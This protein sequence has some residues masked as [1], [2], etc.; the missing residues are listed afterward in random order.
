MTSRERI[1]A[2]IEHRQPDRVPLDMGSTIMSGIM[3]LALTDL[4]K[5]LGLPARVVKVYEPYQMLGEVEADVMEALGIDVMPVEP[6]TLFFG[7]P[8]RDWKPYT[9]WDGTPLLVPGQFHPVPDGAG[10]FVLHDGGDPA[11]P[12]V[13]HTPKQGYYFDKAGDQILHDDFQPPPLAE[14]ERLYK[15]LMPPAKLD[16]LAA[17]AQALRPTGKALLLGVWHDF[18][19]PMVGNFPDWLCLM[20]G[21]PEYVQRVFELKTEADLRTLERVRKALGDSIDIIGIDGQD[22][23]TQRSEMFGPD[24]FEQFH[25]PYYT[26]INAWIHA[27]TP[28]KTWKHTCGA[29]RKFLPALV[30]SGLDCLNPVQTSATGMDARELKAAY[31]RN[32][33]FW[34]AGVDTQQVLPFGTPEEVYRD[35]QQRLEIFKP[36]GGFVFNTIHNLQAKV[37]AANMLAMFQALKDHGRY[38]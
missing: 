33:T 26:A 14:M 38:G 35:V 30:K 15:G 16:F 6:E 2:A 31:G 9:W 12:V 32:L 21:E 37:P 34:G 4:R 7:L 27:H 17:R 5:A 1:L 36:G 11:K 23:G 28:W 29:N 19:A 3:A 22:Y 8:R 13:A 18:G 24:M 20:A 10:G 25:L